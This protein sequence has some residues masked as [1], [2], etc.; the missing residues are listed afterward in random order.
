MAL[1]HPLYDPALD[2]PPPPPPEKPWDL[3]LVESGDETMIFQVLTLLDL[4]CGILRACLWIA[5]TVKQRI[6]SRMIADGRFVASTAA[7]G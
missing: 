6:M 5:E 4:L 3:V 1:T 7:E 2:P